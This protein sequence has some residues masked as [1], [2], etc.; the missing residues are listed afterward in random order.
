MGNGSSHTWD[1]NKIEIKN[2]TPAQ[3]DVTVN[4][5]LFT[6]DTTGEP[7]P[8]AYIDSTIFNLGTPDD[9]NLRVDKFKM[10]IS[11]VKNS[12]S[13]D[14]ISTTTYTKD[15][16]TTSKE[17]NAEF[18]VSTIEQSSQTTECD[19]SKEVLDTSDSILSPSSI[20]NRW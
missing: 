20:N 6:P 3:P 8:P 1:Y 7:I 17:A 12:N 2:S 14:D 9:K 10:E 11:D 18:S 16:G 4:S 19:I 15:T 5:L 13:Y